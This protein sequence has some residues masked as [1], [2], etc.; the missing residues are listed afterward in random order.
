[1]TKKTNMKKANDNMPGTHKTQ[2][3][4][5]KSL[6]DDPS[7]LNK[8]RKKP[9]VRGIFFAL[10][11][12]SGCH[13]AAELRRSVAPAHGSWTIAE[14]PG[15]RR[16]LGHQADPRVVFQRAKSRL[17]EMFVQFH[18]IFQFHYIHYL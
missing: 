15:P 5:R 9:G 11:E 2:Q 3:D 18:Y 13:D 14:L 12:V 7:D 6:K 10:A 17:V 4:A 1:M 16:A 8:W